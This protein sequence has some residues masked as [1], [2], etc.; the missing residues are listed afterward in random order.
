[1]GRNLQDGAVGGIPTFCHRRRLPMAESRLRS[2]PMRPNNQFLQREKPITLAI[3]KF[4][5]RAFP[6]GAE[7]VKIYPD[8][9][10]DEL[11]I[12]PLPL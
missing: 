2:I 6:D 12:G 8:K 7:A 10:V 9:A 4:C 5:V 1:M 3:D 11:C